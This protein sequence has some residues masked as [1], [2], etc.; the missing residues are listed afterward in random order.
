MDKFQI[1]A[2][3]A[4]F[5]VVSVR[6]YQKYIKKSKPGSDIKSSNGHTASSPS[7]E[8]DYEPYTKK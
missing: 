4:A 5:A 7:R 3:S 6:I 8:D 1:F 2:L